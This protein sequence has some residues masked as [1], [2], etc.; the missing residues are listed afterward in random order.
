MCFYSVQRLFTLSK[1][2]GQKAA[3]YVIRQ[4]PRNILFNPAD[5]EVEVR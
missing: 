4:Y 3:Q 5:P 2:S 1:V